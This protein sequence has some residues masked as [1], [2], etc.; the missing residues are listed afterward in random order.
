MH[1][2]VA[3]R[4]EIARSY[5]PIGMRG[6]DIY[7]CATLVADVLEAG[8][9]LDTLKT[10]D[11]MKAVERSTIIDEA[12]LF[13]YIMCGDRRLCMVSGISNPHI[14]QPSLSDVGADWKCS[15][16]CFR[17]SVSGPIKA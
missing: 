10:K 16:S 12:G 3:E 11:I 6:A 5:R 8:R 2:S 7:T 9:P 1:R 15:L 17:S 14:G 4:A 13:E